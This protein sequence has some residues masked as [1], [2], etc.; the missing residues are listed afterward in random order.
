MFIELVD[1]L[2]CPHPHEDS[3]LV[4]SADRMDG[5]DIVAGVLGCPVCRR[6]FAITDR[7]ADF[8]E[9]GS[10]VREAGKR[11]LETGS[12]VRA[13]GA[14]ADQ[15]MRLAAFLNLVDG[16]GYAV[17]CGEWMPCASALRTL[18]DTHL[19]LVN[20]PPGAVVGDGTSGV[21]IDDVLPLA[22]ASACGIAL[23]ESAIPVLVAAALR[24]VRSKGRIV[25]PVSIALPEGVIEL[26]R[27]GKVWVG[28]RRAP[29]SGVVGITRPRR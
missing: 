20:P 26:A 3:W 17:L 23:D 5:R 19:L 12:G 18:S 21:A 7:V 6:Q 9:S 28:E 24:I 29:P 25:A 8:R 16:R 11:M 4:A 1:S 10:R 22:T 2:R 14:V 15:A 13:S 27:D